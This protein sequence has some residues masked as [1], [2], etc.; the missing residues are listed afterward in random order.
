MIYTCK[1]HLAYRLCL[2]VGHSIAIAM[3]LAKI[4]ASTQLLYRGKIRQRIKFDEFTV[5]DACVKLNLNNNIIR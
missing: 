3:G 5:D 2:Y 1:K 4:M